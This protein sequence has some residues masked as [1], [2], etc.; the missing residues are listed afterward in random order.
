MLALRCFSRIYT[1]NVAALELLTRGTKLMGKQQRLCR[2]Q[3]AEQS[4]PLP[5]PSLPLL[6]LALSPA[7]VTPFL[8][9]HAPRLP[10]WTTV[11]LQHLH[12]VGDCAGFKKA[13][14]RQMPEVGIKNKPRPTPPPPPPKEIQGLTPVKLA[15]MSSNTC[16]NSS[17][18]RAVERLG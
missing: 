5:P 2:R 4:L 8:T 14:Y 18:T 6:F 16:S 11:S 13:L 10:Q 7:D 3:K 17:R 9:P 12:I 1:L 15:E